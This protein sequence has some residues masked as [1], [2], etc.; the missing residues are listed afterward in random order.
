MCSSKSAEMLLKQ[1]GE[2][3]DSESIFF[4]RDVY[5]EKERIREDIMSGK[6]VMED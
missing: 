2:L 5:N 3:T 1:L 4:D 6:I